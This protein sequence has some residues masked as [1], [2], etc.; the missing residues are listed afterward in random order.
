MKRMVVVLFVVLA[1]VAGCAN[2]G[3]KSKSEYDLVSSKGYPMEKR[4]VG[5]GVEVWIYPALPGYQYHYYIRDGEIVK[6]DTYYAGGL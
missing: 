1:M 2:Y 3:W 6:F 5:H 4:D